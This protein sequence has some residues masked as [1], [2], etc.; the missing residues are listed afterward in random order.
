M[1]N[2]R[3]PTPIG[4][5]FNRLTILREV[6]KDNLYRP[7]ECQCDCGRIHVA[8]LHSVMRGDSKS[9]GCLAKE[10]ARL[11]CLKRN[12]T[13]GMAG[14]RF[15]RCWKQMRK[16]GI[17]PSKDDRKHY[18]DGVGVEP[19]WSSFEVFRDEM[20]PAYLDHAAK[21]GESRTTIDR[22]DNERG[23]FADNVRWATPHVQSLNQRRIPKI[24][25]RGMSLSSSQWAKEVGLKRETIEARIRMGWSVEEALTTPIKPS[26]RGKW[27]RKRKHLST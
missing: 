22:I 5:K 9:C 25:F 20:S 19:R 6:T 10:S 13:H 2:K 24:E 4:A 11:T 21:H 15:H 14:T 12:T 1:Q 27:D 16:R 26:N 7:V 18:G 23:Y 3:K 17:N 8:A